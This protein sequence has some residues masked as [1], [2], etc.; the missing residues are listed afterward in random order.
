[1]VRSTV[2]PEPFPS[3][4]TTPVSEASRL[5]GREWTLD[6]GKK[7]AASRDK[8]TR[9]APNKKGGPG[10]T[11]VYKKKQKNNKQVLNSIPLR[12]QRCFNG[13]LRR[14]HMNVKITLGIVV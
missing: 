12:T 6:S 1:M 13:T 9:Q 3:S 8:K 4:W 5:T 11:D 2:P 10:I 14:R 7:R